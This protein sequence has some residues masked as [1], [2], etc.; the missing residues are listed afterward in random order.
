MDW[1]M[2]GTFDPRTSLREGICAFFEFKK[3]RRRRD[4]SPPPKKS[5]TSTRKNKREVCL[6]PATVYETIGDGT[7]GARSE[8]SLLLP[9]NIITV[10]LT[11]RQT[12]S[13]GMWGVKHLGEGVCV[14]VWVREIVCVWGAM[15]YKTWMVSLLHTWQSIWVY[16][17]WAV[18]TEDYLS[19]FGECEKHHS[20]CCGLTPSSHTI[21]DLG[22]GP[23]AVLSKHYS[24]W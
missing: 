1:H 21:T 6:W 8:K 5:C 10:A 18:Y 20:V 14:C 4:Q 13:G 11:E 24:W 16:Q 23:S 7:H 3:K 19:C 22:G 9:F 17:Q 12:P 15:L 2:G